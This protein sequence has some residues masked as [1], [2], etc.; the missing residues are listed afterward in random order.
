MDNYNLAIENYMEA[1]DC[2]KITAKKAIDS[3]F[4]LYGYDYIL[5]YAFKKWND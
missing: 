2:N 3:N 5:Y 4:L 1:R